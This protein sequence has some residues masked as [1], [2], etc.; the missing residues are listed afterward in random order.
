MTYNIHG[1]RDR[2]DK[3]SLDEIAEVIKWSRAD[4]VGLQ[5]VD[6][7]MPRSYM[8]NEIKYLSKKLNMHYV[9]GPNVKLGLGLFG[10]G[11]LSTF[12]IKTN[13]NYL[14]PSKG[15]RRGLLVARIQLPGEFIWFLTTHL[16]LN[17]DERVNQAEEILKITGDMA[18]PIILTGDL[19]EM[20]GSRAHSCLKRRFFDV[21][22][23]LSCKYCSFAMGDEPDAMIDYIMYTG[24]VTV[25]SINVIEARCSDH[26]PVI[27]SIVV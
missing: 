11:I 10:N 27:C 7:F 3:L 19:N 15:E 21:S 9:Y 14:L 1:G 26:F 18:D 17:A 16:G 23:T 2:F 5:E 22:E 12:P 25:K 4:I 6:A 20:P 24:N 8:L 13:Q